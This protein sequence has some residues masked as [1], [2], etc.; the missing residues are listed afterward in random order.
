MYDLSYGL[1][2][3]TAREGEKDNGCIVNT[4]IQVTTTPNRVTVAVNKQNYTHDMVMRTGAFNIS[5]IAESA[6]F[7]LFER[8]GFQSGRTADKL[9]GFAYQRAENG[10][11]YVPDHVA[12]FISCRVVSTLDLGT[13]TMFLADVVDGKKLSAEAPMT[14]AFYHAHVKPKPAEKKTGGWRCTI[15]GYVYEGETLPDDFVCPIC[16]HGAQDF[17]KI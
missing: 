14:Y 2:V 15:C 3:L 8:F 6:P 10:I 7:A 9:A 13:H 1:Y 17:E 12:S 4:A 11:V 16:K 5:M